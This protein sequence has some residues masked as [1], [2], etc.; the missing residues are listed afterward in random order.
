M[1]IGLGLDLVDVAHFKRVAQKGGK[2]FFTKILTDSEY[3]EWQKLS[4]V[5]KIRFGAKRYAAKE[6]FAKAC[7]TGIGEFVGLKDVGVDHDK[8]GRPLLHFSPNMQKRLK[9]RFG[10]SVR[11]EVSISDDKVA[12][13]VVILSQD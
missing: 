1:I 10:S 2:A 5:Q 9:K 3:A 7:G 12:G 11:A 4:S 13:A 8:L 6:A